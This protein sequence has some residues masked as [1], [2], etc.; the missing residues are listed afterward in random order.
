MLQ[1]R[2]EWTKIKPVNS[3]QR[4]QTA[5]SDETPIDK[6]SD[7]GSQSIEPASPWIIGPVVDYTFVA[8]GAVW[9]MVL[10]NLLLIGTEMP[11]DRENPRH[12]I[13]FVV[14]YA[15]QHALFDA[16]NVATYFRLWGS[17]EDRT[18][19]RF[20]R[21]TLVAALTCIFFIGL[22]LRELIGVLVFL[23]L[24]IVFWHFAMQTFGIALIYCEKRKYELKEWER[25]CLRTA[26]AVLSAYVTARF[27]ADT[28]FLPYNLYG[29]A[30][31]LWVP[32]DPQLAENIMR[33]FPILTALS[34]LPFAFIVVRNILTKRRLLPLPVIMMLVTVGV[35]GVTNK[36]FNTLMWIYFPA[37]FHGSQYLALSLVHNLREHAIKTGT[38]VR[39]ISKQLRSWPALNYLGKAILI[40]SSIY[41]FVPH[42]INLLEI[43]GYDEGVGL[44]FVIVNY[45]QFLTDAAMWRLRDERTRKLLV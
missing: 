22:A 35:L 25:N 31:P 21:T 4:E 38:N 45:H 12:L 24:V 8:G 33:V 7:E 1:K 27:F 30:T 18:S 34:F 2:A 42:L 14:I 15:A 43:G 32:L 23:Y 20:Y 36:P 13:L 40:G 16:H 17:D 29:A 26:M 44:V 37:L 11:F 6:A 3:N 5:I 41:I 28:E 19:Y 10:A 9:L 39:D